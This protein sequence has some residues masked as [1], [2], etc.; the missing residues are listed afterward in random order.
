VLEG[1]HHAIHDDMAETADTAN[2]LLR[3]LSGG[4]DTL[5]AAAM[6]TRSQ[7]RADQGLDPTPRREE[8]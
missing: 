4:G 2:A 8:D 7:W 1:D 6:I 5:T 3:A